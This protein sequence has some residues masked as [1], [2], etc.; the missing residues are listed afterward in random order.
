MNKKK[1]I[2]TIL[3]ISTLAMLLLGAVGGGLFPSFFMSISVIGTLYVNLLKLI[4]I[5]LLMCEVMYGVSASVGKAAG[6]SLKAVLLF[7]IMF[8]LCF[9]I[10]TPIVQLIKPAAGFD[11]G[12]DLPEWSGEILTPTVSSFLLQIIPSNIFKAMSDGSLLPCILFSAVLGIAIGGTKAVRTRE[13]LGELRGAFSKFL[14]YIMYLTPL[15]VFSLI[16]STSASYGIEVLKSCLVYVLTAWGCCLVC[17]VLVMILPAW[18]F[19]GVSPVKYISKAWRVWVVSLST[20]SSA[21][22]LPTTVKVC[23]EDFGVSGRVT[24]LVVPLGCTIHMCGGAVSFCLLALFSMQLCG[25]SLTLGGFLLM[26]ALAL[27]INMAAPGI[28]GGG[29]ALGASYLAMLGI[30][31]VFIGVYS[32]VYRL[33]DMAYTTMNVTGDITANIIINRCSKENAE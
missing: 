21:A 12:S 31:I 29:I 7:V 28:P 33:L 1:R 3:Y 9:L 18:I 2:S 23:N 24:S 14:E 32:G 25:I 17:L 11:F 4:V 6:I 10:T 8:T 22:T 5:P 27:L 30:P 13:I 26:L 19:G 16:G 15:A 20:C